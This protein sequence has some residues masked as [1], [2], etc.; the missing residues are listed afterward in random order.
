MA[1]A[2]LAALQIGRETGHGEIQAWSWEMAAWFALTQGRLR[3]AAP[4]VDTGQRVGGTNSVV[5]QL[6]AQLAKAS[7]R[8]GDGAVVNSAL[9]SGYTRLSRPPKLDNPSSEDQQAAFRAGG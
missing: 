7:A 5:V 1:L 8:L 6:D 2:G 9:E 3:D 4:Y